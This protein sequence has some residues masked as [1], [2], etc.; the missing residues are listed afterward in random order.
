MVHLSFSA[1]FLDVGNLIICWIII[2]FVC[3][4][5]ICV[6]RSGSP[7]QS[8]FQCYLHSPV[9]VLQP[10][11]TLIT[12]CFILFP[13]S[14]PFLNITSG[15]NRYKSRCLILLPTLTWWN[16]SIICEILQKFYFSHYSLFLTSIDVLIYFVPKVQT[17]CGKSDI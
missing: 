1:A 8:W 4:D 11:L 17:K 14:P 7:T 16:I 2:C 9:V 6:S 12:Q 15:L 3:K 10:P 5:C 13:T